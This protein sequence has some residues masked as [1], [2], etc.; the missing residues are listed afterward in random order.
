MPTPFSTDPAASD[1]TNV[2]WPSVSGTLDERESPLH[3]LGCLS[4]T[5]GAPRSAPL[6]ITAIFTP[7]A[8]RSTQSGT[9][10][11]RAASHCHSHATP[12]WYVWAS[13][14]SSTVSVCRNT[15]RTT[16]GT[17]MPAR[18]SCVSE[19]AEA[20]LANDEEAVALGAAS[21][22]TA[23]TAQSIRARALTH[24]A[25]GACHSNEHP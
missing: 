24:G 15:G 8:A 13:A 18:R 22:A 25:I 19:A 1:E 17:S 20:C 12:G 23:A 6:S 5:S 21:A 2:P 14:G 10:F 9:S 16:S 7:A 4:P 3:V 11:T